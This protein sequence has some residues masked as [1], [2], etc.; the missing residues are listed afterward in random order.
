MTCESEPRSWQTTS[1]LTFSAGSPAGASF[2]QD[3]QV[4][5]PREWHM[6]GVPIELH[7]GVRPIEATG[8]Q[9]GQLLNCFLHGGSPALWGFT[10]TVQRPYILSPAAPSLVETRRKVMSL[11]DFPASPQAFRLV[12]EES[13]D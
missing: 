6:V 8:D 5:L 10:H 11:Q 7:Q 4:P 1:W 9:G 12:R 3:A 2:W 13:S